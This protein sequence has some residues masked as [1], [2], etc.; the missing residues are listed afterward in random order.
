[1]VDETRLSL[2]GAHWKEDEAWEDPAAQ[3]RDYFTALFGNIRPDTE[4]EV[5]LISQDREPATGRCI[6]REQFRVRRWE[7]LAAEWP[8]FEGLNVFIACGLR[9]AGT[10]R[11]DLESVAGWLFAWADQDDPSKPIPIDVPPPSVVV[12]SGHGR[13]LYWRFHEFIPLARAAEMKRL[14]WGLMSRLG[15]DS[16]SAEVV[17][18]LRL[19]GTVNQKDGSPVTLL[20]CD[21][22]R[23]Y[24]FD[25]LQERLG[26]D[27]PPRADLRPLPPAI[28]PIRVGARLLNLIQKG[29]TEDCGFPSPSELDFAV[30]TEMLR[31]GHTDAE[32]VWV[33][34]SPLFGFSRDKHNRGDYIQRTLA[35][36]RERLQAE[37]QGNGRRRLTSYSL[38]ESLA[39]PRQRQ[40]ALVSRLVYDKSITLVAGPSKIGKTFWVMQ[41]MA[42]LP[43]GRPFL[44]EFGVTAPATSLHFTAELP[45]DHYDERWMRHFAMRYASAQRDIAF[46]AEKAVSIHDD[47]EAIAELIAARQPRLVVIDPWVR[48]NEADENESTEM[49]NALLQLDRLIERFGVSILIVHHTKKKTMEELQEN[50][51]AIRGSSVLRSHPNVNILLS[52]VKVNEGNA[53]EPLVRMQWESN[54]AEGQPA[55]MLRRGATG[56]FE[57][58]WEKRQSGMG[59]L[60]VETLGSVEG[61]ALSKNDLVATLRENLGIGKTA[62]YDRLKRLD[63]LPPGLRIERRRG[64][65]WFVL[66][67]MADAA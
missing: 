56:L 20:S 1:M 47:F 40:L 24:D 59:D 44:D 26:M 39:M 41:L 48:Y 5:R 60:I 31:N 33:F 64:H 34:T 17:R 42:A 52:R 67:E 18:V 4:V 29:W 19:P 7:D 8:R 28:P 45:K 36:A 14:L 10:E 53:A 61:R 27:P 22:S 65:E 57:R 37:G 55:L 6:R 13:H 35:N 43:T 54:F 25:D 63:V 30:A 21:P 15:A 3:G 62:A 16:R 32:V 23:T 66:D 9:K 12:N 58:D 51:D 11:G 2:K 49:R 50:M 46:C 38:E